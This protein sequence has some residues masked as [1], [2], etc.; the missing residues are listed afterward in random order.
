V[1]KRGPSLYP[2]NLVK[3]AERIANKAGFVPEC[4]EITRQH[5]D[6]SSTTIKLHRREDSTAGEWRAATEELK[7]KGP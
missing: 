5:K 1:P 4:V 2:Q 6:G 3:R 7:T